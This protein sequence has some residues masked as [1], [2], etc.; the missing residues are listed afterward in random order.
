M[1]LNNHLKLNFEYF[2]IFLI[3]KEITSFAFPKKVPK[4][5]SPHHNNGCLQLVLVLP[6]IE[7]FLF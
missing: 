3:I 4:D 2:I 6:N 5:P 7:L 1:F